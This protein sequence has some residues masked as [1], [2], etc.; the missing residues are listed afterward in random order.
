[1]LQRAAL[2]GMDLRKA[3]LR[4]AFL[5]D[6]DLEGADLRGCDLTAARLECANLRRAR[7]NLASMPN[8]DLHLADL[9]FANLSG[10]NAREEVS[11]K[12]AVLR[13]ANLSHANLRYASL[14]WAELS[15]ANLA[16]AD[17]SNSEL[18]EADLTNANLSN[19]NLTRA[20]IVGA[21]LGSANLSDAVCREI[22][23]M[24]C[25]LLGTRFR[26][27]DLTGARVWGVSAWDLDMDGAIQK[28]L[29]IT[30]DGQPRITLDNLEI[31]QFIYLLLNNG[32]LRQVI[33]AIASKVVLILGRF[34]PERKALLDAI[35]D[36][37]RKRNYLPVLFDFEQPSNQSTMETV[38]TLAHMARFVIADITDAKSVLQELRG[39][40]PNRP[41]LP[42]QLILMAG[43]AEPG[44]FDF[45]QLFPWVLN[46]H[47]YET[48]TD[49]IKTIA[50]CVID[51]VEH[52]LRC[53][54]K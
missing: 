51:P 24:Q 48:P 10:R 4:Q 25:F 13:Q 15:L 50:R 41:S 26:G 5:E 9:S 8:A 43:Q 22:N 34:T 6:A 18:I 49:L 29:V 46:T 2:R 20:H 21:N 19:A 23:L 3:N 16:N 33:E 53:E 54:V 45:F 28:D 32:R 44:M 27:A 38:S 7:L 17:L 30:K 1:M 47:Y 35:R 37:L 31:A 39:I 42:V 40:V 11:L 36:E 14:C 12:Y 52:R